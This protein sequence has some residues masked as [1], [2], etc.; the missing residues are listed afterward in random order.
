MCSRWD[1]VRAQRPQVSETAQTQTHVTVSLAGLVNHG[2]QT[3]PETR[4]QGAGGGDGEREAKEELP[5]R[6]AGVSGAQTTAQDQALD[7]CDLRSEGKVIIFSL[8][9]Q[10]VSSDSG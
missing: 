10:A 8:L 5:A 2:R 3:G 6:G 7:E 4:A 9:N 1:G